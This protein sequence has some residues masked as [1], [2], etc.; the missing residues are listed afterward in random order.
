MELFNT[1]STQITWSSASQLAIYTKIF[2]DPGIPTATRPITTS[3]C[4]VS[5]YLYV[6]L[7]STTILSYLSKNMTLVRRR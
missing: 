2:D 5:L 7:N 4:Y 6:Q 1:Y 3:E